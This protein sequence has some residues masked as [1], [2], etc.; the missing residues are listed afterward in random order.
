MTFQAVPDDSDN[1]IMVVLQSRLGFFL[2]IS[3]AFSEDAS[4]GSLKSES[5]SVY[6]AIHWQ[7][8]CWTSSCFSFKFPVSFRSQLEFHKLFGNHDYRDVN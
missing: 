2:D 7:F 1:S 3:Q 5:E 6:M 8:E 4:A